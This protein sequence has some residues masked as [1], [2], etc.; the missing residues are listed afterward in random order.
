MNASISE[1]LTYFSLIEKVG[2]KG[3]YQWIM[4]A[5]CVMYYI[6]LG[7]WTYS[8]AFAFLNPGF[9]CTNLSVREM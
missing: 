6:F 9:D 5:L 3:C 7:F 2:S 8:L 4:F 1:N